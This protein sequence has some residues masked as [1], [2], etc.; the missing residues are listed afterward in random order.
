D[1]GMYEWKGIVSIDN[2]AYLKIDTHYYVN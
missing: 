2:N 1:A